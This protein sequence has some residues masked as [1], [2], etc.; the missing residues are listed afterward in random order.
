MIRP[1][2]P[3]T[4]Y[5]FPT[6]KLSSKPLFLTHFQHCASPHVLQAKGSV[7]VCSADAKLLISAVATWAQWV[8]S[9]E[10]HVFFKITSQMEAFSFCHFKG[11]VH[12]IS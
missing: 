8:E 5:T 10:I 12:K 6:Q 3:C 2:P 4:A 1:A 11:T 9:P 7:A